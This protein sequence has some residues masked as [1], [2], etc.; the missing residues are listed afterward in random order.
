MV[1]FRLVT[2][3]AGRT[4]DVCMGPGANELVLVN[5]GLTKRTRRRRCYRGCIAERGVS[6][7]L[8]YGSVYT[9]DSYGGHIQS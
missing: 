3:D 9:R 7:T 6:P 8:N 1:E 5:F 4:L 2:E